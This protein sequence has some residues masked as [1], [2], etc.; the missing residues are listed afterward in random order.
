MGNEIFTESSDVI[1]V[2]KLCDGKYYVGRTNNIVR[3]IEEHLTGQ[4]SEWTKF[5]PPEGDNPIELYPCTSPVDEDYRVKQIMIKYGI[6]NVRGGSYCN[7]TLPQSQIQSLKAEMNTADNTCF[8]CGKPGH[9]AN[10]C[11]I[12]SCEKCGKSGHNESRCLSIRDIRL[13]CT[14]CGRIG[15][16]S[17][18]CY[19]NKSYNKHK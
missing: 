17:D 11:S 6:E 13:N 16:S 8:K 2:L 10:S 9:Y 14:K 12:K 7:P 4:G 5:Y 15:H 1:Y 3:R 19:V 18:M